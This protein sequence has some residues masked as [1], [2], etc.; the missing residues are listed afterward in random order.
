MTVSGCNK[1]LTFS[2]FR[3]KLNTS[4]INWEVITMKQG[5]FRKLIGAA[6][7]CTMAAA[8][9]PFSASAATEQVL[10]GYRGDINFDGAVSV[11]DAVI[12]A[13]HLNLTA[14]M[15]DAASADRADMDRNGAINAIDLTLLK[16]AMYNQVFEGIYEE[17]E[18]PEAQLMEAPIKAVRPSVPSVGDVKILM[19]T[20][21]FPDCSFTEGY[22]DEQVQDMM[23][24]PSDPASPLYPMESISGY[25][26]RASYGRLNMTG[27]VYSYTSSNSIDS[28]VGRTDDLV[29]EVLAA[30]DDRIDYSQ[31]DADGNGTMDT[32]LLALPGSASTDDWWPCNGGYYNNR[33]FDGVVLGNLCVGG[34][35]LSDVT[36]FISTWVHELGHG[37]GLPDY[38]KY[39]NTEDGY[40]GLNG[41]AGL[42]MMDDAFGDM[43]AFSKLMLGWYTTDEVMLYNGGTQTYTLQSSQQAPNCIVIPRYD[44]NGYLSEYFIVEYATYEGNNIHWLFA[45]G[46]IRILHCQAEIVEGYW[47]P[48]LKYNNYGMYYD[49]SN[50]KQRVLRLVNEG[51]GFF[52]SGAVINSGTAGFAWYDDN[53][54]QTVDPGVTVSVGQLTDG[55]Y[56]ITISQ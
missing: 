42:E 37:M 38:Y 15:T 28:Y 47:G 52:G 23:F 27:E 50:Q 54:Y 7:A 32:M 22:T 31:F 43:S 16:R 13:H 55:S 30:L 9:V 39:V 40:Y 5:I 10:V 46:G 19:V 4:Y 56:T 26:S 45:N 1:E 29:D 17:V 41:D 18:I 20:V 33:Y 24:G 35:A 44:I 34:W 36:G 12:L 25:F 49:D 3:D 51:N 14:P 8:A 2:A 21:N 48:E 11:T 53:G 6:A